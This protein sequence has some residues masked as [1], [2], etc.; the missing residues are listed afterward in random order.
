MSEGKLTDQSLHVQLHNSYCPLVRWQVLDSHQICPVRIPLCNGSRH[1]I[2]M[3]FFD[4][5]GSC[6]ADQGCDVDLGVPVHGGV[7]NLYCL[8]GWEDPGEV[9]YTCPE[10][11]NS[12]IALWIFSPLCHEKGAKQ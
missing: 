4:R 6:K 11:T 7:L 9:S 10:T 2:W 8:M 3:P 5:H 1:N 12:I